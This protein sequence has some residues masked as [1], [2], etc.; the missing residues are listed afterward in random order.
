MLHNSAWLDQVDLFGVIGNGAGVTGSE[1]N[2]RN[3]HLLWDLDCFTHRLFLPIHPL[4]KP[5]F[6]ETEDLIVQLG[7]EVASLA[8]VVPPANP[9]RRAQRAVCDL[10]LV[11]RSKILAL[12]VDALV[13]V[14]V[15]LPAVLGLVLVREPCVRAN[16]HELEG[17]SN[18]LVI[19]VGHLDGCVRGV[20]GNYIELVYR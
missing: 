1:V 8:Q 14:N 2:A 6:G 9:S 13:I 12:G 16:S 5:Q 15:V 7:R 17:H 18:E 4:S 19:V 11:A 20:R 3:N 10:E